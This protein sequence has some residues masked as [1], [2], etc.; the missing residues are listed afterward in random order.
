MPTRSV[1]PPPP[2][3]LDEFPDLWVNARGTARALLAV[4]DDESALDAV[5]RHLAAQGHIEIDEVTGRIDPSDLRTAVEAVGAE[6][7]HDV[8]DQLVEAQAREEFEPTLAR[9]LDAVDARRRARADARRR[10]AA[11]RPARVA[12]MTARAARGGRTRASRAP[13]RRRTSAATA[14]AGPDPSPGD[15]DSIP[16]GLAVTYVIAATP[17]QAAAARSAVIDVLRKISWRSL[18]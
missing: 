7:V 11:V 12:R 5:V 18:A 2:S 17:A 14:R 13:A 10:G 9:H 6:S 15:D 16:A 3:R 4:I 8:L 1:E